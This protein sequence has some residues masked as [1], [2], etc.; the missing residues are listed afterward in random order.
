MKKK[1]YMIWLLAA[2]LLAAGNLY[3]GGFRALA[4]EEDPLIEDMGEE[5]IIHSGEDLEEL[6][7]AEQAQTESVTEPVIQE[8]TMV[9]EPASADSLEG[10]LAE[11]TREE[12]PPAPTEN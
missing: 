12:S 2:G 4:Q 11:L 10:F 6:K 1:R 3:A 9:L 7:A 8:E 5:F